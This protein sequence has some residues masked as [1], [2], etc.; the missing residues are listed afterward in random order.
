MRMYW[1]SYCT[2]FVAAIGQDVVLAPLAQSSMLKSALMAAALLPWL[3]VLGIHFAS[4]PL[5]GFVAHHRIWLFALCWYA[6]LTLSAEA[7]LFLGHGQAVM[8]EAQA[9]GHALMHLGW[10]AFIPYRQSRNLADRNVVAGE[11]E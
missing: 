5:F 3:L 6:G 2:L 11:N 1:L 8:P 7:L 9:F 4:R 10:V